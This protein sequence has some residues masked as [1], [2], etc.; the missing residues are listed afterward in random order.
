MLSYKWLLPTY[1]AGLETVFHR[2]SFFI[3][4][5]ESPFV[6]LIFQKGGTLRDAFY[7][8]RFHFTLYQNLPHADVCRCV[9]KRGSLDYCSTILGSDSI[10]ECDTRSIS[11]SYTSY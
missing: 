4:L 10:I 1:L 9:V 7:I 2:V 5:K 11:T 8:V 3:A 6:N